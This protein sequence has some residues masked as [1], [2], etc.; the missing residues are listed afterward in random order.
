MGTV[1]V[2]RTVEEMHR[3]ADGMRSA[4]LRIGL[5]P[6]M[7]Y[8]H[9]GHSSLI[10][11]VR[12]VS[13]RTVVSIFVNPAQFGPDEDF[14]TYPRDFERDREIVRGEGGD[15]IYAPP[16]EE[17]YKDGHASYVETVRL[18][19]HLCGASRP[20]HF[21]GVAT[22]VTKLFAAVKPHVAIF[23]QKDAQQAGVVRRLVRDLNLDVDI[24]IAPTVREADGLARSSRN[25]YLTPC[26]RRCATV[27]Y[28]ALQEGR[29]MAL[30]G[31]K[32]AS[33]VVDAMNRRVR[34][35]SGAEVDYIAAVDAED[36]QPVDKMAGRVLLA[37]A[38]QF[39]QSRLIDNIVVETE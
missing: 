31:E 26:V 20:G 17:M 34:Q 16:P 39:G 7:G 30:A 29:D 21:R 6:T 9:A 4:G 27:L 36:F 13:D 38:V 37:V 3:I 10:R 24:L 22:V 25:V 28:R 19:D 18:A 2:I 23:G 35:R 11:Q 12:R 8:L 14:A 33:V 32:R 5:V 15:L 1:R